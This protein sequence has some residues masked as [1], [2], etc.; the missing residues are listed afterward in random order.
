MV[1]GKINSPEHPSFL[2]GFLGA[3]NIETLRGF[4][5]ERGGAMGG[6]ND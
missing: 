4:A 5:I 6:E 1:R 2:P 3:A